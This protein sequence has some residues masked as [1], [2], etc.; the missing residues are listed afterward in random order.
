MS[1]SS[2]CDQVA[3]G[4]QIWKMKVASVGERR[5]VSDTS[6][7]DRKRTVVSVTL[8]RCCLDHDTTLPATNK[9]LQFGTAVMALVRLCQLHLVSIWPV[10]GVRCLPPGL[11]WLMVWLRWTCQGKDTEASNCH[12]PHPSTPHNP[13][14]Y[15]LRMGTLLHLTF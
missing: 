9:Q 2:S 11:V 1:D 12:S 4:N 5:T 8:F 13:M 6:R 3:W 14:R 15:P 10:S 7:R